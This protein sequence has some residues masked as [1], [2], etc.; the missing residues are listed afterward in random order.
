MLKRIEVF[1]IALIFILISALILVVYTMQREQEFVT[2]NKNIQTAVVQS[3]AYAIN[4]QL[5]NKRRHVQLFVDEYARLIF[6][7]ENNP[8]DET[9]SDAITTRLKQRF[10]DFFTYTITDSKGSPILLD[11]DS[12]VGGVCQSDLSNYASKM[13]WKHDGLNNEVVIHPQPFYYHYDIMSPLQSDG[14][15]SRIF[16]SSFYANEIANIIKTHEIPGLKL[17]LTKQ[18]EPDLIEISKS[19]ARDKLEREIT[20]TDNERNRIQAYED[21][22]DS[23]WRLVVLPDAS[24]LDNYVSGLWKEMVIILVLVSLALLALITYMFK[25]SDE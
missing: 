19:G 21:V 25:I 4:L 20:L 18:S 13:K 22:P 16:F 2:Y 11:I 6:K 17:F 10:P 15:N 5:Q 3:A 14:V 12:F 1:F 7:L 24:V 9:T 23:D 8:D